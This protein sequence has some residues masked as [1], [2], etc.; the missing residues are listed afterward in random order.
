MS[1]IGAA[2]QELGPDIDNVNYLIQIIHIINVCRLSE[3][4]LDNN[5][6]SF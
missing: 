6:T 4:F 3:Y 5:A 1:R 2:S